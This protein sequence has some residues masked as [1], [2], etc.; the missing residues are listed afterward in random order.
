MKALSILLDNDLVASSALATA[1]ALHTVEESFQVSS[2]QQKL[3]LKITNTFSEVLLDSLPIF[4]VLPIAAVLSKSFHWV[5]DSL[6]V[7]AVLHPILDH[8]V[9]TLKG[10]KQRPGSITA[11]AMVLPLGAANVLLA[12]SDGPPSML[13]GGIGIIISLF[14]YIV[15]DADIKDMIQ[16]SDAKNL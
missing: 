10:R 1:I 4:V 12:K 6:V 8:V 16:R 14:L 3:G 9:L 7:V 13:G 5:R 11:M 2:Y 15:A